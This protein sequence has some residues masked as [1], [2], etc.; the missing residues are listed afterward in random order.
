MMIKTTAPDHHTGEE[1]ITL[2]KI[3]C[4]HDNQL[5]SYPINDADSH[6]LFYSDDGL[7]VSAAAMTSLG[8]GI[9]E[10]SAFTLPKYRR[11]GY[12]SYLLQQ[13]LSDYGE[14]DIQFACEPGCTDTISVL[15]HLQAELD[16]CEYQMEYTICQPSKIP[17]P[18]HQGLSLTSIRQEDDGIY[19]QLFYRGNPI[20]SCHTTRISDS[21]VCLHQFIILKNRRRQGFGQ[22]LL[23]L[24]MPRLS[25]L[26]VREVILQVSGRNPAALALYTKTGFSITRTLS[27]YYY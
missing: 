26:T 4:R 21:R 16:T 6:Y 27:F 11:Q 18:N 3:C 10:C 19:W 5:L 17:A 25:G 15:N 9:T 7:L 20:G 13:A 22:D 14:T 24:L 8:G 1:L 2:A 12:F 23:R